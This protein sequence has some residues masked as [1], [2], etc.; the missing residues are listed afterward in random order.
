MAELVRH[1]IHVLARRL[2]MLSPWTFLLGPPAAVFGLLLWI[3]SHRTYEVT[4]SPDAIVRP[5]TI[6]GRA[7]SGLDVV[8]S[9]LR[10]ISPDDQSS[11]AYLIALFGLVFA[12]GYVAAR[13]HG[14]RNV[15]APITVGSIVASG[16]AP[17]SVTTLEALIRDRLSRSGVLPALSVPGSGGP[18]EQPDIPTSIAAVPKFVAQLASIL[19]R[20]STRRVGYRLEADMRRSDRTEQFGLTYTLINQASGKQVL[21][22]TVWARSFEEAARDVASRV[23]SFVSA[24]DSEPST[25]RA[26]SW[27]P[28]GSAL[29]NYVEAVAANRTRRFD[30]AL[31]ACRDAVAND[32]SALPVRYL[33]GNVHERLGHFYDA[34]VTYV[35]AINFFLVGGVGFSPERTTGGELKPCDS[36]GRID[37]LPALR[38]VVSDEATQ[39]MWRYT[40]VLS[41][42][43]R[44]IPRWVEDL[45]RADRDQVAQLEGYGLGNGHEL[46]ARSELAEQRELTDRLDAARRLRG[47]MFTRYRSVLAREFPLMSELIFT[48]YRRRPPATSSGPLEPPVLETLV[49]TTRRFF[50]GQRD[51]R[52]RPPARP[53]DQLVWFFQQIVNGK[54]PVERKD[55]DEAI[56][57]WQRTS[58]DE[59]SDPHGNELEEMLS[60]LL[61]GD[62]AA[63]QGLQGTRQ[64]LAFTVFKFAKLLAQ[65][66]DFYK[67]QPQQAMRCASLATQLDFRL[68]ALRAAEIEMRR[69]AAPGF[70]RS[71]DLWS[72]PYLSPRL[73]RISRD[74]VEYR[75]FERLDYLRGVI[76]VDADATITDPTVG[77][78]ASRGDDDR[79]ARSWS[80]S[81]ALA[82]QGRT[83]S[84]SHVVETVRGWWTGEGTWNL[85]YYRACSVALTM[86]FRPKLT[87]EP[88]GRAGQESWHRYWSANDRAAQYA[89]SALTRAVSRRGWRGANA[90]QAGVLDWLLDEDPDLD[91]LRQHPRF[92]R[93]AAS[94]IRVEDWLAYLDLLRDEY[95]DRKRPIQEALSRHSNEV[96]TTQ[97]I[98][99]LGTHL[100]NGWRD[101]AVACRRSDPGD[102]SCYANLVSDALVREQEVWRHLLTTQRL[103]GDPVGRVQI[104]RT[105]LA[106]HDRAALRYPIFPRRADTRREKAGML[107]GGHIELRTERFLD[108]NKQALRD[109]AQVRS[110]ERVA[111]LADAAA[112]RWVELVGS[113]V[114]TTASP[115]PSPPPSQ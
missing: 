13:A 31:V 62:T 67:R 45:R 38:R 72:R 46:S 5:E 109:L 3:E 44:W 2:G 20:R 79:R 11:S 114:P 1:P 47:F 106:V 21:A 80:R 108:E 56:A 69:L 29:R 52:L 35:D 71:K 6:V 55:V 22:E 107:K 63:W 102:W 86:D 23:A 105:A 59:E 25:R 43:D 24:L 77:T 49:P 41:S 37:G 17:G 76:D 92:S 40:T 19:L 53:E 4:G 78:G 66:T 91:R 16:E 82:I 104:W 15:S 84:W 90:I 112:N 81:R 64:R 36:K 100:V 27:A 26:P 74:G 18:A 58:S 95:I 32:P 110:V 89:V 96:F 54:L 113:L 115:P 65:D 51:V 34:I 8:A 111:R 60:V 88:A 12:L 42:T 70:W 61:D 33:E 73:V 9:H 50:R 94:E 98:G 97:L 14:R 93:W 68:F 75:F 57:N 101:A 83:D 103:S 87:G 10:I 30:E 48:D 85:W 28:D 99:A 39:I 7:R